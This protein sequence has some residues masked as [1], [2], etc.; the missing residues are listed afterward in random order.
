MI[1]LIVVTLILYQALLV[2][3]H[4]AV[5]ATLAAAFGI[6]GRALEVV[7]ILLAITF[8]TAQVL[9]FRFDS[10]PVRWYYRFATYWFGLVHFLFVGGVI[11]FFAEKILFGS[12]HY[13]SP[14]LLGAVSFGVLFLIH[15]YGTWKSGSATTTLVPIALPNLPESWRGKKIVFVSDLHLGDVRG[16]KFAEKVVKKIMAEAPDV[17]LIGGDM[18]DGV[19]CDLEGFVA[20]FASL[21]PP[22]GVYFVTGNHDYIRETERSLAAIRGAGIRVL[23]NEKIDLDGIQLVGIDY[24]SAHKKQDFEKILSGIEIT[25]DAPAIILKHVPDNIPVTERSGI[26]L[27]FF[28]H[29]HNGQIF[30]LTVI[31]RQMFQGFGYGLNRSKGMQTYTS[32]GAGTWGPPLRLGTRSEIVVVTL[33]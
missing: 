9:S 33:L 17:V 3:V 12:D 11:F 8:V 19:K 14:A 5:Y 20:P 18:Y 21:R 2:F 27:A 15:L 25:R 23:H 10:A 26:A 6:G 28:G 1:F 30:P 29:T 4:L 22:L 16:R 24:Q 7:F 32:S 31:T 13:V